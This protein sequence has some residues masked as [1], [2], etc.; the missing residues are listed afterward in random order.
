M[1]KNMKAK[2]STLLAGLSLLVMGLGFS[3]WQSDKPIVEVQASHASTIS[4]FTIDE[5]AA[6]RRQDPLGIRFTVNL[7]TEAQVV[8]GDLDN[9]T[10]GTLMLPEDMLTGELTFDTDAVL[11]IPTSVWKE[12]L[13]VYQSVLGGSADDNGKILDIPESYYNRPIVARGYIKGEKTVNGNVQTYTYYTENTST[14]SIGYIAKMAQLAGETTTT[15]L[16]TIASQ[17]TVEFAENITLSIVGDSAML[18]NTVADNYAYGLTIGGI[19]ADV[20]ADKYKA[21]VSN[22]SYTS[23]DNTVVG[24]EN[25][26]LVAKKAG[27]TTVTA[28]V[29][30][31][32]QEYTGTINVT[33][34]DDAEFASKYMI[35]VP[36]G[37]MGQNYAMPVK[38]AATELKRLFEEATGATI[39]IREETDN[40]TTDGRYIAL[41]NTKLG[42]SVTL[43]ES[44]ET[45]SVV[46]TVGNTIVIKGVTDEGTMY[47][48]YEWLA[49][50]LGYEYYAKD[51]YSLTKDAVTLINSTT[52]DWDTSYV[53][54]IEYSI[55]PSEDISTNDNLLNRYRMN[56]WYSDIMVVNGGRIHNVFNVL[57]PYNTESTSTAGN[58][59]DHEKWYSH[60]WELSSLGYA[61]DGVEDQYG[62]TV[63]YELCYQA[64]GDTNEY[65]AMVSAAVEAYKT[66]FELPENAGLTKAS[67]SIRDDEVWCQCSACYNTLT[68]SYKV[69][70][71]DA[72]LGFV[73]DVCVGIREW[74]TAQNDPRK[75]TFRMI[76]LAYHMTGAA[77]TSVTTLDPYIDV[78][79]AES[80]AV[81]TL[82]M[83]EATDTQTQT[84]YANLQAWATLLKETQNCTNGVRNNNLLVWTYNSNM[85]E[86]L[87]PYDS[88]DSMRV[89]YGL[90]KGLNVDSVYN[91]T[92]AAMSG[93]AGLKKYLA[94]QLAWNA[95]PTDDQW[96]AWIDNFFTNAYG[97]G[98]TQ[99]KAWFENYLAYEDTIVSKFNVER[100]IYQDVATSEFF[101]KDI[102]NT[103]LSYADAALNALDKND[104]NYQTYY[105]NIALERLSPIYLMLEIYG[106]ELDEQTKIGYV[107]T[108][109]GEA[110]SLGIQKTGHTVAIDETLT[111][112]DALLTVEKD[113][114][115]G[116]GETFASSSV[117]DNS[118]EIA[119][120][121]VNGVEA[122][123]NGQISLGTTGAYKAI[124]TGTNGTMKIVML[125]YAD[126]VIRTVADLSAVKY[127]VVG[128]QNETGSISGYYVL[129][130]DIDAAGATISGA[131][132]GWSQNT[133][134]RGV[135]DGRNYTISNLTINGNGIFGTLGGATVQNV[136]F[137]G[138]TLGQN[139]ALF[140]SMSYK[141]TV[142]NVNVTYAGIN[143]EVTSYAGLLFAR[144]SNNQ[145][146]WKN[147]ILD[148]NKLTV[149]VALG[150]NTNNNT[151][152]NV[153]IKAVAV[154]VIGYTDGGN[155]A[156]TEWPTG[157]TFEE[158]E[159]AQEVTVSDEILAEIGGTVNGSALTVEKTKFTHSSLTAGEEVSMTVNGAAVS[160]TAYDGY[161][162][163]DLNGVGVTAGTVTTA[164]IMTA[165][166]TIIYDNVFAVTMIINTF[167]ELSVVKYT[168]DK[169]ASGANAYAINGYYV[170]G[171]NIDGGNATFSGAIAAWNA[172]I[173]FCGTLDGRDYTISNFNTGDYGLFGNASNAT[174]KNLKLVVNSAAANVLTG[175]YRG[176]TIENVEI[177]V[178]AMSSTWGGIL[179]GEISA[180]QGNNAL[181][182][183]VKISTGEVKTKGTH[184]LCNTYPGATFENV[185]VTT[186]REN[187]EKITS[188]GTPTSGVTVTLVGKTEVI[189]DTEVVAETAG[190]TFTHASFIA[191]ETV[192]ATVNGVAV[193]ATA[194]DGYVTVGDLSGAGMTLGE[195]GYSA[196]ITTESY[197]ISYTNVFYVTQVIDSFA[198]LSAVKY[199]GTRITGYYVLGGNISGNWATISG[200]SSGWGTGVG[201]GGTFDGR[202]YTIDRFNVS[203]Y[204]M[205]GTLGTG[206]VKNVN[207]D[208]VTLNSG[209]ALLAR[210]MS[211]G[212]IE[213]VTLKLNDYKST[214]GE[215]GIFVSR[216]TNSKSVY[217]NVT[218][219]ANGLDIYNVLGREYDVTTTTVESFVINNAGKV[220]L[221]GTS[222][223]SGATA[224]EKPNGLTINYAIV[225]VEETI[226]T[227]LAADN[228]TGLIVNNAN[229]KSGDTITVTV[230]EATATATAT[231]DGTVTVD[232]SGLSLTAGK[233]YSV[234]LD[235]TNYALTCTDVTFAD[236]AIRTKAD[237]N[238]VRYNGT[239]ITGYFV[240]AN[241]I[242][243]YGA[244]TTLTPTM[245]WAADQ[246]FMGTFD[247]NGY[248][249]SGMNFTS[250]KNGFFVKIGQG[251]YLKDFTFDEVIAESGY[252]RS[253]LAHYCFGGSSGGTV[254]ENVTIRF[255]QLK[256]T[257]TSQQDAS[258]MLIGRSM[259]NTN[260]INVTLDAS[261]LDIPSWLYV[262]SQ[263]V[264]NSCKFTNCTV[265]ANSFVEITRGNSTNWYSVT[266][267]DTDA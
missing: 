243:D 267:E 197:A 172:G 137:E 127:T 110:K 258:S 99:M 241:D 95:N 53:P 3:L 216:Q 109:C 189:V 203:G 12:E 104:S 168:G 148:A 97:A 206:T 63:P 161:V 239:N 60:E 131:G 187:A 151:Y 219:D 67:L 107:A 136:N 164:T 42:A 142:Q 212:T 22:L 155:T 75:D 175:N 265:K 123:N 250:V 40:E 200:A 150:Y 209:A 165:D 190:A 202:G 179:A 57:P 62:R 119:S 238:S 167:D 143:A 126:K 207:F 83:N 173:G 24:V 120:V 253:I 210:T 7:G 233:V 112:Y 59:T 69:T 35:L 23:N 221:Y 31:G 196:V 52:A 141:S 213:N 188:T 66:A 249:V 85:Y 139:S 89:N 159:L 163:A 130:N 84:T 20:S 37:T 251:A 133:G 166:Y 6:I 231:A 266:F 254:I 248:K 36:A 38:Y 262:L 48:T 72:A 16:D 108:F 21:H 41:G 19:P 244:V 43:S 247:G 105:N 257:A 92:D 118:E 242:L 61:I 178:S 129:G 87:A 17:A 71:T 236:K 222:D 218:V 34:N 144:Q 28:S 101:T 4:G 192:S 181:V 46:K 169:S 198:E 44:K 114:A 116:V 122:Y 10:C 156:I 259:N 194:Y 199:T 65:N 27:S 103:W 140:A 223:S 217:R 208:M 214:S 153:T 191:G 39:V 82:P 93:W 211:G 193:T 184:I 91:Y 256:A 228:A 74:L 94:S 88:F 73:N 2:V 205:F 230:N 25:G 186:H 135:F 183:D 8:Y 171:G 154:T 76:F 64:G 90:F 106:E 117:F 264:Q 138:V 232:V 80:N 235:S 55:S 132:Y 5:T 252:Q 121:K 125:H 240:L 100:S 260:L 113:V 246:G 13:A 14:R 15:L 145:N 149:P 102:L 128:G 30:L 1:R 234:V 245:S 195:N 77:P 47:G 18:Y 115:V 68:S 227:A 78:W 124:V 220:T 51:T 225:K 201:F 237:L 29:T 147:V 81:Y 180:V 146:Y 49:S 157:I 158:V 160:A 255:K 111:N 45:A 58:V 79:F 224:I 50:L 152:E 170:L 204:G 174:V 96:N 261:G 176:G 177:T 9:V 54:D 33:V 185:Q 229:I 182:K 134:F 226:T 162:L 215:C 70:P 11:D 26:K 86:L 56:N 32:E 98:A 263:E